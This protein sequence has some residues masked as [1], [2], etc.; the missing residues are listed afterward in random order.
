MRSETLRRIAH[1]LDELPPDRAHFIAAFA[2]ALGRVAYADHQ[3]SEEENREME[4]LVAEIGGLPP[5]QAVLTVE[6]AKAQHR[7]FGGTESFLVS[8]DFQSAAADGDRRRLLEALFAVSAAD[9]SISGEEEAVILQIT[10]EMGLRREDFLEA[11]SKWS[12][13]RSVI[14]RLKS[15]HS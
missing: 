9:D 4:R 5:D 6:I 15:R 2:Y 10:K 3:V 11:R 13:K 12:E 14:Q 7:L 8:K 1:E